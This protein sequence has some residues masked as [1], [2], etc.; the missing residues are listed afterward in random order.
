MISLSVWGLALVTAPVLRADSLHELNYASPDVE[1]WGT[2]RVEHYDVAIRLDDPMFEGAEVIA[3]EMPAEALDETSGWTLWLASEL[4]LE[5]KLNVADLAECSVTPADGRIRFEP[6]IPVKVPAGGLY[7]GC[8]FDVTGISGD[9][10]AP[11]TVSREGVPGSF[12]IHTSRKYLKWGDQNLGLA[13][14]MTVTLRGDFATDEVRVISCV[15]SSV[16]PDSGFS[17]AFTV[18]NTGVTPVASI[19]YTVVF[20]GEEYPGEASF[21]PPLPPSGMAEAVVSAGSLTPPGPGEYRWEV[22]LDEVN[23]SPNAWTGRDGGDV[24]VYAREVERRPLYEEFTGTWCGWCP[25]GAVAIERMRELYGDSFVAVVWH[26]GDDVMNVGIEV[27]VEYPG[28]PSCSIDRRMTADPFYGDKEYSATAADGIGALWLSVRDIPSPVELSASARVGED[29][30]VYVS[31]DAE[32][33]RPWHDADLRWL[34]ML[35]ADGLTG[36]GIGWSQSNYYSGMDRYRGGDL[37]VLVDSPRYL[38]GVPFDDVLAACGEPY[39]D[40][41]SFPAEIEWLTVYSGSWTFS[42]LSVVG[43]EGVPLLADDTPLKVVA[44]V[45]DG[46]TGEVLN[47]VGVPVEGRSGTVMTETEACVVRTDCYAPDG[48]MLEGAAAQGLT[49]VVETL[50]DGSCRVKRIIQ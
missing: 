47:S 4:R 16:L 43:S 3:V 9:G 14:D 26:T 48:T 17:P 15:E 41:E 20:E 13:L 23:S 29:G 24:Y 42:P 34:C 2:G 33:V 36:S 27:P 10:G 50:D 22:R 19:G 25:R 5:N 11:L 32:F 39:G 38:S 21:D 12:M 18:R 40:P 31:A 35:V 37:D 45:L 44:A 1:Q 49:I 7:A 28:A 8:S 46:R 6:E 30:N